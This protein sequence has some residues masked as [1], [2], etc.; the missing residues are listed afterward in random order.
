MF[1]SHFS[2]DIDEDMFHHMPSEQPPQDAVPPLGVTPPQILA[3]EAAEGRRGA[4]WRLLHWV[5]ENDPRAMIAVSSSQDPRL[6]QHLLEWIALGTWAGKVFTVPPAL[7]SPYARTRLRTLF[8]P[9]S[10]ID[11]AISERA[12]LPA[13]RDTRPAVR[14]TAM[15]LLGMMG[16]RAAIP[17]LISALHDPAPNMRQ[18]A[19]EALG[20][21]GSPDAVPALLNAL[22]GSDEQ[23]GSQIFQALV[24]LGHIAVPGLLEASQS[25]SA[26]IRWQSIRALG[27]IH[28]GRAL[29]RLVYA[30]NDTDRGV[31][32]MAAKSL[33]AFGGA[34]IKPVLRLLTMVEM[35]PWLAETAAYVLSKQ[36]PGHSELK[37]YLDP[38]IQQMQHTV[39]RAGT[40]YTAMKALN[41]IQNTIRV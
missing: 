12:L 5:I 31:A 26:W 24:T 11:P 6:A 37:P 19:I 34:A 25:R 18:R 33:T 17:E 27:E 16:S 1:Y 21:S 15:H 28:D 4:A 39:Y 30:L 38:V 7:R 3:Q 35:T 9:P 22:H 2:P 10:G 14:E 13:L 29:S 20:R 23:Q 36:F 32:W 41:Q 40:C 8:M